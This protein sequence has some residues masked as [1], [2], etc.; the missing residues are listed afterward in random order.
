MLVEISPNDLLRKFP[1][2]LM[3][4]RN[5]Q[6]DIHVSHYEYVINQNSGNI[7]HMINMNIYIYIR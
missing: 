2:N 7:S 6:Y 3:C 5:I 1:I 4:A